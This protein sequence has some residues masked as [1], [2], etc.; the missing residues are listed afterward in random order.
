M[1]GWPPSIS[2]VETPA[3]GDITEKEKPWK[4]YPKLTVYKEN[5][6][7]PCGKCRH[8]AS[9]CGAC[10]S[11]LEFQVR[12]SLKKKLWSQGNP[13]KRLPK[14]LGHTIRFNDLADD[15]G[16][17][18]VTEMFQEACDEVRAALDPD[19]FKDWNV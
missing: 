8:N 12:H 3:T 13:G 16:I 14:H 19:G 18:K 9:G 1:N 2:A 17:L 5:E 10:L 4:T 6:K 11:A 15:E 7:N